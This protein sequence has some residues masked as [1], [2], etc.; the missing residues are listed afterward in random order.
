M[1]RNCNPSL[2]AYGGPKG[3]L[4]NRNGSGQT[5]KLIYIMESIKKR[6]HSNLSVKVETGFD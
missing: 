5:Q 6:D 1:R 3:I 4:A 2:R